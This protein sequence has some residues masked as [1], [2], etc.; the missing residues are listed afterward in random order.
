[1]FCVEKA[2]QFE[3]LIE[4]YMRLKMGVKEIK[5]GDLWKIASK[6]ICEKISTTHLKITKKNRTYT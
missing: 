2:I 1:M 4:K 3:G 5:V 6:E